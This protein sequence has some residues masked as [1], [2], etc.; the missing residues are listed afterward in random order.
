M[1]DTDFILA[2]QHDRAQHEVRVCERVIKRAVEVL[3]NPHYSLL[4]R[5][6]AFA[7]T[8]RMEMERAE[9]VAVL[10]AG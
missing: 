10:R 4:I 7:R 8:G 9:W 3:R 6:R 5:A 2:V 1:Y